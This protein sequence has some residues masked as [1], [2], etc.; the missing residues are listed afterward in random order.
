MSAFGRK[1]RLVAIVIGFRSNKSAWNVARLWQFSPLNAASAFQFNCSDPF[2][3]TRDIT[4]YQLT[5][6][7]S[8]IIRLP[9][10]LASYYTVIKGTRKRESKNVG[11]HGVTRRAWTRKKVEASRPAGNWFRL[12]NSSSGKYPS[13]SP[14]FVIFL[15]LESRICPLPYPTL[16]C[17]ARIGTY[18]GWSRSLQRRYYSRV[19][20]PYFI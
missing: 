5:C 10:N 12:W 6:A 19:S 7:I 1:N 9:R 4:R 17:P 14:S 2:I 18:R 15:V 20:D 13:G 8:S 11:F 16:P 3:Q